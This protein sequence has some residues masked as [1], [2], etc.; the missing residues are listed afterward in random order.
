MIN[1]LL[2]FLILL[3]LV[4]IIILEKNWATYKFYH[5]PT[6]TASGFLVIVS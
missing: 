4:F 1:I 3:I 6:R 5:C 2:F